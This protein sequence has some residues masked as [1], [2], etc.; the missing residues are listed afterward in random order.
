M[1]VKVSFSFKSNTEELPVIGLKA[2]D[3][4]MLN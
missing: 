4:G 1:K 3:T 2:K